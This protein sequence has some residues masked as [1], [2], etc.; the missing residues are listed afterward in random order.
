MHAG[1]CWK[2]CESKLLL[3]QT[4]GDVEYHSGLLK[5]NPPS[6]VGAEIEATRVLGEGPPGVCK[7]NLYTGDGSGFIVLGHLA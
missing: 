6:A 7:P 5:K 2:T 1:L 3:D 4:R